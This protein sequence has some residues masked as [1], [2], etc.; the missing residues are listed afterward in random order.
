MARANGVFCISLTY[1]LDIMKTGY[2]ILS[3]TGLGIEPATYRH[4]SPFV[5]T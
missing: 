1:I 2:L 4:L 3:D 5:T